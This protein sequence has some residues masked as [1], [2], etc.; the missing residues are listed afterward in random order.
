V[1]GRSISFPLYFGGPLG[2]FAGSPRRF[3]GEGPI[4]IDIGTMGFVPLSPHTANVEPT[5]MC[6]YST[7]LREQF[8]HFAKR[9]VEPLFLL[10]SRLK[11]KC[12]S[13]VTPQS[14]RAWLN[15]AAPTLLSSRRRWAACSLGFVLPPSA[16][17]RCFAFL[18]GEDPL[19]ARTNQFP[20]QTTL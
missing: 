14:Q 10:C 6:V 9:D 4:V 13:R 3:G 19:C 17:R 18:P 7:C 5:G 16:L 8:S 12:P 2:V 11:T 15:S 1:R 20:T